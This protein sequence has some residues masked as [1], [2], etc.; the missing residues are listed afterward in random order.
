MKKTVTFKKFDPERQL[1][2]GVVYQPMVADSQ[3]DWASSAT[4]EKMAHDFNAKGRPTAVDIEHDLKPSG[5]VVIENFVARKGDPNFPEGAWA[6]GIKTPDSIWAL[7]KSG[8]LNGLSMYGRGER[9]AKG[10]PNQPTAK[11]ELINGE[12]LSV[13]LVGR[14]ANKESF[15]MKKSN[16]DPMTYLAKQMESL[17]QHMMSTNESIAA[18]KKQQT[19]NDQRLASLSASADGR[20]VRKAAPVAQRDPEIDRLLRKR[21][22]LNERLEQVW[23]RPDM[24]PQGT[25]GELHKSIQKTEDKLYAYGHETERAT[26]DTGSA[27]LMR[28]GRSDFLQGTPSSLDDI[29]GVSRG[30]RGLQKSEDEINVTNCLVL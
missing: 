29:L 14:A 6:M 30:T 22:R 16:Q 23:A 24:H 20:V 10:L 19:I 17:A 15:T 13:S 25:E 4:I 2:Y 1:V 8:E 18:I 26:L 21:D 5:C 12:I 7:V 28:G 3:G 27:F 9:V 11:H